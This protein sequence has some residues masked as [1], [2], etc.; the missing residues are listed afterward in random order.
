MK[1]QYYMTYQCRIAHDTL[2]C[3][4]W[5]DNIAAWRKHCSE[6]HASFEKEKASDFTLR[7]RSNFTI[8]ERTK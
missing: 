6:N 5:F 8:A 4:H 7:K 3:G 2:I 1:K